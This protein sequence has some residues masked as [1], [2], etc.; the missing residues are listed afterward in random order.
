MGISDGLLRYLDLITF[1]VY[2]TVCRPIHVRRVRIVVSAANTLLLTWWSICNYK[3]IL[4]PLQFNC[5]R[6]IFSTHKL[7]NYYINT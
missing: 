4:T 2:Y 7:I 5:V 3:T 6:N 1:D